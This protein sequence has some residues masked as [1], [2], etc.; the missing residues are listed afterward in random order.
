M[1]Y[2]VQFVLVSRINEE[3]I[4]RRIYELKDELTELETELDEQLRSCLIKNYIFCQG[5]LYIMQNTM[6]GEGAVEGCWGKSETC[7]IVTDTA[8]LG[9]SGD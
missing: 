1:Q 9:I 6:V 8:R 7:H 5:Y 3:D 2:T 4:Q